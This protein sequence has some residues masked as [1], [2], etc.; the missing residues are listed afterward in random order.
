VTSELERAPSS[1][2]TGTSG[3]G[4]AE[5][6]LKVDHVEIGYVVDGVYSAAVGDASFETFPG[7]TMMLLGPSGC[8]KS[9][10]LKAIAGFLEPQD[11]RIEFDGRDR[12]R[13]GPDRAVVFQEFDQLFPWR[14]VRDNVIYPLRVNGRSRDEAAESAD[15]HLEMMGLSEAGDRFPH[16]LSGGM[17]QRVAIARAFA[18]EPRML[19]MDEPFG[20]LDAQTRSRLQRELIDIVARTHV[21]TLFVTHSIQEAVLIGHRVVVLGQPPSEVV[22]IVD[23]TTVTDPDTE[24]FIHVRRELRTLLAGEGEDVDHAVFE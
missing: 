16:Q 13:P 21:T 6:L 11:G 15:R 7:E 1:P 4:T 10:L 22:G 24:E 17:K 5:P 12:L 20:S 8:G 23:V 9:T 14:N 3:S 2:V 18:L 19:L